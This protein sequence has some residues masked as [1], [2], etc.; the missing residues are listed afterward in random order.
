MLGPI[1]A[2]QE[3][4]HPQE[5]ASSGDRRG[6]HLFRLQYLTGVLQTCSNIVVR[7]TG[8]VPLNVSFSPALSQQA[9]YEIH[10]QPAAPD[11]RLSSQHRRI[12]G[13]AVFPVHFMSLSAI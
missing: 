2:C 4:S 7:D 8:V 5:I 1:V 3:C 11:N 13:H 6:I 9:D 12:K 10:S